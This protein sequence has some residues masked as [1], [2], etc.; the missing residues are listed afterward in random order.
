MAQLK[1]QQAPAARARSITVVTEPTGF[2]GAEIHT[3]DLIQLFVECGHTVNL[4]ACRRHSF[5]DSAV[6]ERGWQGRV[7]LLPTDLSVDGIGS[8]SRRAWQSLFASLPDGVLI[9]PKGT[10]RMGSIAF[11][12]ACR[13]F[14]QVVV[15][16]HLEAEPFPPR[17]PGRWL[18]V[19]PRLDLWRYRVWL[20]RKFASLCADRIIAVSA[21]VRDRL[22]HDWGAAASKVAV[23]QNGVRSQHFARDAAR[24]A[25]FRLRHGIPDDAVVFGMLARLSRAKCIDNAITALRLVLDARPSANAYLVV[26][27]DGP[28]E[29]KLRALIAECGLGERV[30]LLGFVRDPRE[31]VSGYDAIVFASR[32][33]GLPLGLLEGMAAGCVPIVTRIGGMPEAVCDRRYGWVVDPESP[34]A[35]SAA[36]LELL[37]LDAPAVAQLRAN[38]VERVR[39]QFDMS[40]CHRQFI[41]LCG[42]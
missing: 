20:E 26:A 19:L 5:Y 38:A 41:E 10:T 36:M 15:I 12:R 37:A 2:G 18:H 6:Q 35:L 23:V 14:E 40:R 13:R 42:L 9:F 22:V 39:S 1:L 24:R 33:E 34:R 31:V 4:L 30:R 27:G 28:D 17:T 11:L 8:A 16:E 3:L 21:S 32:L 29:E 25:E 7:T